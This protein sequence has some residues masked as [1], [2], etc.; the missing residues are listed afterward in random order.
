MVRLDSLKI[1]P[2]EVILY[3]R[4]ELKLR[5]TYQEI[6]SRQIIDRAAKEREIAVSPEEIQAEADQ[7]RYNHK[8]ESASQTFSWLEE[9]LLTPEEWESGIRNRLLKK[10]L[11]EHLFGSQIEASFAQSKVQ[12]EQAVLY[13]IVVS[14]QPL[15]QEIFYQI[16][17]EEVS[18]FEAAHYYDIDPRR[19][20][21]CGFEGKLSRWQLQPDIAARV[22][23]ANPQEV[24][25]V[26][27][28]EEGFEIWM[29]EEFIPAELTPEI[30]ERIISQLF[31]EWLESELN[32]L[33][34]SGQV[35]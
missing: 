34:H 29:V 19:R 28:S 24:V 30:R 20:L 14:Y 21:A 12:Y 2:E 10:K 33:V 23:G 17:E 27:Q 11:A 1:N 4:H 18:F 9:Q 3:L 25:G 8:L 22:F 26:I 35:S 16:E 32:Y 15:A 5:D 31:N 6:L 13:R 7:F